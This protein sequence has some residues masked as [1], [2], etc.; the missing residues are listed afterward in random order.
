MRLLYGESE[1]QTD[2][3]LVNASENACGGGDVKRSS[4]EED[5]TVEQRETLR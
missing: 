5:T 2:V 1:T 4:S 3:R